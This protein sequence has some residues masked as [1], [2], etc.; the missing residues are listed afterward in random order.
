MFIEYRKGVLNMGGTITEKELKK[1][2]Y[3]RVEYYKKKRVG[4]ILQDR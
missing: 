2:D 4:H 3:L 1:Y